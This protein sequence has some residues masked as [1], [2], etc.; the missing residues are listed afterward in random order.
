MKS[1]LKSFFNLMLAATF[2]SMAACSENAVFEEETASFY[3]LTLTATDGGTVSSS[4]NEYA[5][6]EE[7]EVTAISN[8]GYTFTAWLENGETVSTDA[9]YSFTMPSHNVSLNATFSATS[10]DPDPNPESQRCLVVYYTWSGNSRSLATDISRALNCD[11][12]Q[13]E[14]TTPYAATTDS[15]LYPIARQEISAIDNEGSYPSIQTSVENINEYDVVLVGYPLWYS[16]MATPMQAF[17]HNHSEQLSGKTI[18]LFCTS[19]SSEISG[20]VAD[21]RRLCPNSTLTE[22]LWIRSSAINNAHDSIV[23]WLAEIGILSAD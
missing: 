2:L 5:A 22:S 20:T 14:L 13:V 15:E 3:S 8:E 17:L 1:Y 9:V 10:T 4:S 11:I 19:G 18:A 16:R 12:V 7:V 6:G 21:A 23:D